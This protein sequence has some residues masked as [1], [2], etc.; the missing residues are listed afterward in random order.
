MDIAI[1][2]MAS[3][4]P[5]SEDLHDFW[6]NICS[7][8]DSIRE[9]ADSEGYWEKDDF[10][11]PDRTATDKTY[12]SKAGWV[13]PIHFD[14]VE[15]KLPPNILDSIAAVQLFSLYVSKLALE[16]AGL[17]RKDKKNVDRDKIGVILGGAGSGNTFFP[18]A[19]RQQVVNLRKIL[20]NS[21]LPDVVVEDICARYLDNFPEWNEDSFPGFLGNV[22]CGRICSQF[23]LGGTSCMIDAA[24]ASSLSAIKMAISELKEGSCDAV[25]TGGVNVENSLVSFMSFSKTPA[26]SPNNVSRPFDAESDGMMLGDGVGMLVLKRLE[27]AERDGDRVYAVIKALASA[28]DGRAKSVFAP[29]LEGQVKC[30]NRT[31]ADANISP[32]N[33]SLIEAHGTGTIAGDLTEV[34]SLRHVFGQYG[35]NQNSIALGS[36]KSQIGHTRCAAGAA[37]MIKVALSLYHKVLP[38]TINV[39]SPNKKLDL[40][41]SPFYINTETRPWLNDGDQPRRAALSSFGF[42]GTNYHA[43]LEEH[44]ADYQ[45]LNDIDQVIFFFEKDKSLLMARCEECLA[46]FSSENGDERFAVYLNEMAGASIPDKYARVAFVAKTVDEVKESLRSTIKLLKAND[47][48]KWKHPAGIFYRESVR[49]TKG[50]VVALFSGQGSQHVNM[51]RDLLTNYPEFREAFELMDKYRVGAGELP[52][53]SHVYPVPVFSKEKEDSNTEMLT[54]TKNAQPAIGAV[55][56]GYYKVLK[57]LGLD[58]DFFAGHSYGELSALMAAGVMDEN[59]FCQLSVARGNAVSEASK[60]GEAGKML[61]INADMGVLSP[62]LEK[63]GDIEVSNYN[64][65]SQLVVGGREEVIDLLHADLIAKNIRSK[66]LPVSAAFHTRHVASAEKS[67]FKAVKDIKF[68]AGNNK[69]YSN[70]TGEKYKKTSADIKRNISAQ[71]S[72]P[73]LFKQMIEK[74]NQDG[75][76]IFIEI[77]PRA[78]LSSLVEDVLGQSNCT[79]INVNPDNKGDYTKQFKSSVAQLLVE[80][81]VLNPADKYVREKIFYKKSKLTYRMNGGAYMSEGWKSKRKNAERHDTR[82]FDEYL[83][84]VVEKELETYKQNNPIKK[85]V[86]ADEEKPPL[87]PAIETDSLLKNDGNM[88]MSFDANKINDSNHNNTASKGDSVNTTFNGV[89]D[90]LESQK[91]LS[92]CHSQFQENQKD[93]ISMLD[94]FMENQ[95]DLY[96]NGDDGKL[97]AVAGNLSGTINLLQEM[98]ASYHKNHSLYFMNQHA[99]LAD[100]NATNIHS[101]QLHQEAPMEIA[102]RRHEVPAGEST[103]LISDSVP[104]TVNH[105]NTRVHTEADNS[106]MAKSVAVTENVEPQ[107]QQLSSPVASVNNKNESTIRYLSGYSKD[108]VQVVILKA[109]SEKTGYPEDMIGLDMDLESDLGIDSIKRIEILGAVFDVL[110]GDGLEI[111]SME[112]YNDLDTFDP[113]QLS[114][115]NK[116]VDFLHD[117]LQEII[118]HLGV[119][120]ADST[121]NESI[122]TAT[123]NREPVVNQQGVNSQ[124]EAKNNEI[125]KELESYTK[126]QIIE[127]TIT[128]VS[129]KTGYPK[130]MIG[131]DMDL[132][133]DLGIDSIKRIEILGVLFD[134]LSSEKLEFNDMEDY[135]DLDTFDPE[136]LSTIDKI[137][138]FFLG[139][140]QE[141]AEHMRSGGQTSAAQV[142]ETDHA[143]S[144][145]A[146]EENKVEESVKADYRHIGGVIISS[147][148]DE[149]EDTQGLIKT[150]AISTKDIALPGSTPLSLPDGHIFLVTDDGQG[151]SDALISMLDKQGIKSAKLVFN[152]SGKSG[153]KEKNTY[154]LASSGEKDIEALIHGIESKHGKIGG[155]LHVQPKSNNY[156]DIKKSFV[157]RDYMVVESVFLMSKVLSAS[158]IKDSGYFYTVT[159]TG[160]DL[161]ASIQG[162]FSLISSGFTGLTKSLALEWPD[163]SCRT[164]DLNKGLSSD[165]AVE[166][167]LSELMDPDK[168]LGEVGRKSASERV[169][170]ELHVQNRDNQINQPVIDEKDVFLITGGGR[171]ITSECA[172]ALAK[173]CKPSFILAGRTDISQVIPDIIEE[174]DKPEEIRNKLLK[175]NTGK[176]PIEIEKMLNEILNVYSIKKAIGKLKLCGSDVEYIATDV[177]DLKHFKASVQ[178][179]EQKIGAVTGVIHGAGNISDKKIENKTSDDFKSVFLTKVKGL[180]NI[181]KSIELKKLKVFCSFASIAGYYGNIGQTDYAMANEVLNKFSALLDSMNNDC[182]VKSF[183][184]GP[185]DAGMID[186]TLR[187]LYIDRGITLIPVKD[188]TKEFMGGLMNG[189]PQIL[190]GDDSYEKFYET[191]RN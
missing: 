12:A 99:L 51:G 71:I 21:G 131:L 50:R 148:D 67:F 66:I 40:E 150:Y 124:E 42:G 93:Y 178:K 97:N 185:W 173:E 157:A 30:L 115:I 18:L 84:T 107:S 45:R 73:V 119:E 100:G 69:V 76:D 125:I 48:K 171:G 60:K 29:R 15:F 52:V 105:E 47:E 116:M 160:G 83:A 139:T 167:I 106:I 53:S 72:N 183:N 38:A 46:L 6:T 103:G 138:E 149:E 85:E 144:S 152:Q 28:S 19:S 27:D 82:L 77:G 63:H 13:P 114:T 163:V 89:H 156:K 31:Y 191:S 159:Q 65:N 64:S 9:N 132:E 135:N 16:D 134:T 23:D 25:L 151:I 33:I 62:L 129:E 190:I 70:Y 7:K 187:K 141:V 55:S 104:S 182:L 142:D 164:V 22:A 161:G 162:S 4:F 177:Q 118:V 117:V 136:V 20:V 130:D 153:H 94:R 101:S 10:Y 35:I 61:A 189:T 80:G 56:L 128:I 5:D 123:D 68:K 108:D 127:K 90:I 169:Q 17:F 59:Q 174:S 168:K 43:I 32:A 109:I 87:V 102:N 37:S 79:V 24:C 96:K 155:F 120:E 180:D 34:E 181:L 41:N 165:E 75:G 121:G 49:S 186:D 78:I 175:L 88:I 2:G 158:L 140:L 166:I 39:Q 143:V 147:N 57:D 92:D 154:E 188:G 113:E 74:I 95:F 170:L 133:A 91:I 81:L 126:E 179:A 14:P 54:D 122:E 58:A 3:H 86:K 98:Q 26:L 112:E 1:V 172:L 145:G 44:H 11:D 110:S 137:A 111:D 8:K 176:K 184:W 146:V 36:I